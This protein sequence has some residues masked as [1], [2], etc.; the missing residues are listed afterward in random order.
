MQI[1]TQSVAEQK[2]SKD[3]AKRV[4]EYYDRYKQKKKGLKS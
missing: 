1:V 2:A 4:Q 3:Y